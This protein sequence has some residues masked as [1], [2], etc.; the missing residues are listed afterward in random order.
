[1]KHVSPFTLNRFEYEASHLYFLEESIL[2]TLEQPKPIYLVGSRGTGKTTLLKALSWE[3]RLNNDSLRNQ[4]NYDVFSGRYIGIYLKLPEVQLDNMSQWLSSVN[5]QLHAKV[6]AYYLDLIWLELLSKAIAELIANEIFLTSAQQEQQ[7]IANIVEDFP[8]VFSGKKTA[9]PITLIGLSKAIRDT[10]NQLELSATLER[11]VPATVE[12]MN[13]THKIG[14]FGRSLACDLTKLCISKEAEPWHFKI[15]MDEGEC[16]SHFQQL[17]VNTMFR[18]SKSPLFYIVSFVRK[19]SDTTSTLIPNLTLQQ[20]DREL[21]E[22]DGLTPKRFRNLAE[23]VATVRVQ[24]FL[25]KNDVR[26]STEKSLGKL[27]I[28]S[29]LTQILKNSVNTEAKKLLEQAVTMA[30]NPV[31]AESEAVSLPIYQTYII[32]KL[33]L[34]LTSPDSPT[35]KQRKQSSSEWRKK[36]VAAYLS[37]CAEVSAT[38]RYASGDM[39][40]QLSDMCVRDYLSQLDEIFKKSELTLDQ[41]IK[42]KIPDDDQVSA[43][44]TASAKKRA[45]IPQAGVNSPGETGS[46]IH[47][48]ASVTALIQRSSSGNEHLNSSERGIFSLSISGAS[49]SNE[50]SLIRIIKEAAEAGFLK[51]VEV[52]E[53]T[54]RFRVHTSLAAAYGF[55]YRGAYY[56][57]K[58]SFADLNSLRFA[59]D[60][61][62]VDKISL[63]IGKTLSGEHLPNTPLFSRLNNG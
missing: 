10:R 27:D 58:I 51:L 19:P 7:C 53:H 46:I 37:I 45:S 5:D 29:L 44:K 25:H 56:N 59:S 38:V 8:K 2:A 23:G 13:I 39:V 9:E 60:K 47:G 12:E 49:D 35:W 50:E 15:C 22:L 3:E 24:K 42:G 41:F 4:L 20:A 28:N 16:L 61:A 1:M 55:S 52:D 21:K 17:V 18:L 14:E 30:G 43:L 63:R 36:M 40:L 62:E 34:T 32:N 11:S 31:F 33:K 6:L 48:L 57:C 54:C 26:F